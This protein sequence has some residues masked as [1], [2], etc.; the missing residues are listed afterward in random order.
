MTKSQEL[1]EKARE[2]AKSAHCPYSNFHVGAAL[3]TESGEV[4]TGCN[5]ENGSFGLTICAER[6]AIFK[7]VEA[8]H[9]IV[10]IGVSCA[11][12]LDKNDDNGKMPCG[13][14]RQVMAEFMDMN[15]DV[16]VDSVG[17]FKLKELLP[18]GFVLK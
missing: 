6:V 12:A 11:D 1:V 2:A 9:K 3:R 5:I 15:S 16:H 18:F 14:C 17:S 13:A 7:A 4:I 10:E 8:G